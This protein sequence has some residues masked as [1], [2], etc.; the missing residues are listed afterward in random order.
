MKIEDILGQA[1]EGV[2]TEET[3]T[4]LADAFNEAV[5]VAAKEKAELETVNALQQLDE[6]H[7]KKLE[8]LLEAIDIDHSNKLTAVL[9]KID[10]DQT[11]KLKQVIAHYEN[12]IQEDAKAFKAEFTDMVSNYLDVYLDK[13]V[14]KEELTEAVSNKR[15]QKLLSQIKQIVT[16]DEQF[17]NDTIREAV[18]D[19]KQTID[20]LRK[21]LNEAVKSNIQ[22]NQSLKGIKAELVLEKN[23]ANFSKEKRDYTMRAL[24][25]KDPEFITENFDYVANMFDREEEVVREELKG[26]ATSKAKTITVNTPKVDESTVLNESV[27]ASDDGVASYL[28]AL[29]KQEKYIRK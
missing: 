11:A 24:A 7:S 21:E 9:Q 18:E 12:L 26:T 6:E 5:T 13:T 22:L 29:Q 15:A 3:K 20:T 8:N 23:T 1:G 4:L 27:D 2:L 17:V 16:I 25:G 14:P 19:G 28:D 10:D